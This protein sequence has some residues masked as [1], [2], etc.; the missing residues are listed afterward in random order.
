MVLNFN[1]RWRSYIK[2]CV[3]SAYA[4]VLV[5]G[6]PLTEFKLNKGLRQGDP[7]SPFLYL[8]VVEGLNLLVNRAVE[9]GCL[10]AAVIGTKKIPVSHLQYADNT[11]FT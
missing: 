9:I 10:E 5:N 1:P 7:L 2:A 4:S 8:L 3:S 11:M 6:C